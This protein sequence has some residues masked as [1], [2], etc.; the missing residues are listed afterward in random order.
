VGI[1]QT[2]TLV[3][4]VASSDRTRRIWHPVVN[5]VAMEAPRSNSAMSVKADIAV[6]DEYVRGRHSRCG[7]QRVQVFGQHRPRGSSRPGPSL[8]TSTRASPTFANAESNRLTQVGSRMIEPR[9]VP[10]L[11]RRLQGD[12]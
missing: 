9:N 4:P 1:A 10:R 11:G 7:Q 5:E 6:P 3:D 2:E 12:R 8:P